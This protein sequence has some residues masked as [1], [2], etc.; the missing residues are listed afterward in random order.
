[1]ISVV[2]PFYNEENNIVKI[3]GSIFEVMNNLDQDF[4]IIAIDDG[5][6]DKTLSIL[7]NEKNNKN[8]KELRILE[9]RKNFG[10]T[11]ALLA[12]FTKSRGDIVISMDG[13]LQ[14]DP[15]DIPKMLD[16]LNEG[17]DVVCGWRKQRKDPLLKRIPSKISNFLNRRWNKLNIHD[18]GC[19]F[20][21]YIS[22]AVKSLKITAEG[23]RYIPA[24]LSYQGFKITETIVIHHPRTAGKTKYGSGRLLRGF[25]DLLTLRLFYGYKGRP[26][27]LFAKIGIPMFLFGAISS[28]YMV[29]ERIFLNG[30]LADRPAF[31]IAVMLC[32]VSLQILLTGVI[33][34]FFVRTFSIP[35]ETY[36]I[37][38]E[39]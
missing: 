5:S 35:Q 4:E 10:Q 8:L 37:R 32:T 13:D 22:E 7:L 18:S 17:Y 20:R 21:T 1:M 14:N 2:I 38:K 27:L 30:S 29:Y 33:A 26:S 39:H 11:P 25:I 6:D 16:K 28:V 19:T 15:K 9:F 31:F 34:E 12:G 24:I 23:H 3:L 36:R